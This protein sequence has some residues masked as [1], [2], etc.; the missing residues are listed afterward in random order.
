M[1]QLFDPIPSQ[2]RDRNKMTSALRKCGK[3]QLALCMMQAP[4]SVSPPEGRMCVIGRASKDGTC[5]IG[6]YRVD[7]LCR[8]ILW[9]GHMMDL[10]EGT[11]KE[12]VSALGEEYSLREAFLGEMVYFIFGSH[13]WASDAGII[14]PGSFMWDRSLLPVPPLD[15]EERYILSPA[16][17][18]SFGKEGRHH[19]VAKDAIDASRF[20]PSMKLHLGDDFTVE[21]TTK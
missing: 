21:Y 20:I 13:Q 18:I 19:L 12:R 8:G 5:C 2:T 14:P 11:F 6:A 7:S 9:T 16:C 10:D 17:G 4:G 1:P 3:W 15:E